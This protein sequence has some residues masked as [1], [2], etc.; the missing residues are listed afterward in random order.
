[1]SNQIAERFIGLM[2]GTSMD[3]VDA[4]LL[5]WAEERPRLVAALTH[6]YP[7]GLPATLRSLGA[8]S[9]LKAVARAD[10]QVA[11]AFADAVRRLLRE[12]RLEA[13]AVRAIGSHGQTIWHDPESAPAASVQIGDPNRIA[14][15]TGITVVADFRRRDVAAGGQGAPLAPAFHRALLGDPERASAVINLGGI[16]NITLLGRGGN[17]VAGFDTG[18]ASTLLDAWYRQQHAGGS[19]DDGGRWARRGRVDEALLRRLL[20]DPFFARQPPKSTGPERFNL[21]WLTARLAGTDAPRPQ[22]VQA[23]LVELTAVS[24]ANAILA[25]APDTAIVRVCGGG[26]HN[27]LL[28]ERLQARLS[29]RAVATTTAAGIDPD[30]VEAAGFAWLARETL[31]GRPGNVPAVTGA[32]KAVVLGGIYP[33]KPA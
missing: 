31:A 6:P 21:D 1:M 8:D 11:G 16:A 14:A 32:A 30:F 27:D 28:M 5:E 22:D 12:L 7:N 20:D 10:A 18:P 15:A 3:G 24:V 25:T 19:F 26:V 2:S 4:A 9:P 33:E 23:T 13:R 29:P 17:T